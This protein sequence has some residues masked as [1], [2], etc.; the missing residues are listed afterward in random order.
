MN[1]DNTNPFSSRRRP[2]D[3]EYE[4]D[5]DYDD[6][7][8]GSDDDEHKVFGLGILQADDRQPAYG[9]GVV[10]SL[11]SAAALLLLAI[12]AIGEGDRS[13]PP[14]FQQTDT[15]YWI[16]A[17]VVLLLTAGGAQYA[18]R[19]ASAAAYAVGSGRPQGGLATAWAVP[20]ISVFAAI[21]LTATYH[22]RWML[23]FGPLIAFLGTAG[24]L[25]SR[26]LLDE[27]DEESSRIASTIHTL[28]VHAVAF[29][30]F[31]AIYLNKF[32]TWVAAPLVGLV[33][34]V[35]ILET[36]E[37]AG[38]APPLR[39]F[40]AVLG[41]WVLAQV[42]IALNWWPTWGW[43][44]GAV[45]LAVFYAIAGLMLIRVQREQVRKRDLMEYG[46]VA[47]TAL[48]VLALRDVFF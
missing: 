19:T 29:L 15:L 16:I 39:I 4:D 7:I 18:E 10:I 34:G 31:S 37:R 40:Y 21:V 46:A 26:D 44:G 14:I 9:Q 35:L 32:D 25:L 41:G 13:D 1:R 12:I 36:L 22:N 6:Y 48:L 30:A 23:L 17:A 24:A 3:L 38:I 33:G 27:A 43:T 45:L 8:N 42:M 20:F 28:V 2:A 5:Q 11:L 47:G